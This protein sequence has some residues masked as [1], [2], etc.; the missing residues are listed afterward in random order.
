[1]RIYLGIDDTDSNESEYG[2]G[3]VARWIEDSLPAGC[4]VCGVVRQQLLVD[5]RIPYTS[6]NSSACVVVDVND[7]SLF[8]HI[9]TV[10]SG[11]IEKHAVRGSDPGL[12][13]CAEKC[14]CRKE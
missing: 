8:D 9:M 7:E 5:N 14:L 13:V 3:K 6:H 11:H 12:C 2:T 10:A 4:R 1:M